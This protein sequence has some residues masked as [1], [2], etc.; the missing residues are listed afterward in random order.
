[1]NQILY[2]K[3]ENKSTIAD[4]KKI[5]LFFAFSIIVFG[6]AMLGQGIYAVSRNINYNKMLENARPEISVEQEGQY[7]RVQ[8]SHI[9]PI[10]KIEYSWNN[11]EETIIDGKEK[12]NIMERI[13][14]PAGNNSFNM[15]VTDIDNKKSEFTKEY[16]IETGRDIQK[17]NIDLNIV[18][19]FIKLSVTDDTALS[20]ITYRWNE[21]EEKRIEP[22]G[23][24]NA[25]IED[26]IEILKGKN[27]LTIIAVD[28]S[29]NTITKKEIFEGLT[30]P[31]IELYIDGD[32][33]VIFA[34]HEKGIE[35]MEYTLN[36]QKVS[37]Q[38]EPGPEMQYRQKLLDGY[39]YIS[40][41]AFSVDDTVATKDGEYTYEPTQR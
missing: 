32:S 5:V 4:V 19:N 33:F 3:K 16:T 36:G 41:Q 2:R 35:H 13:E 29:N 34:K 22:E 10:S 20:Y 18:G 31:T 6:V 8:I 39:N 1:M 28:S 24:E 21:D 40:V 7:L 17:P 37:V 23:N 27:T 9:K 26:S 15:L 30:K 14:L 12:T 25:K 11:D 38:I